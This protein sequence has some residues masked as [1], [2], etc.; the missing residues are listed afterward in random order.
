MHR[1]K[2]LIF[3]YLFLDVLAAFLAW[4]VLYFFRK[5]VIEHN[6]FETLN[7]FDDK[8]FYVGLI[9]VPQIW[10]ALY[11]LSGTYTDV[12]RKSRLQELIKTAI[13]SLVGAV[14][15]FFALLLDDL[16]KSYHDYYL[17]FFTL[18]VAQFFLNVSLRIVFLNSIKKAIEKGKI[19]FPTIFVGA[20]KNIAQEL[21]I[22]AAKPDYGFRF[23]GF[24]ATENQTNNSLGIPFLGQL[25]DLDSLMNQFLII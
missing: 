7:A 13:V 6:A 17:T 20:E 21:E 8:R 11:Y 19:S 1:R 16:V 15:I 5:I 22:L 10:I 18:F 24:V 9:I 12:C 4:I 2:K 25:S 3:F 23:V 14:I